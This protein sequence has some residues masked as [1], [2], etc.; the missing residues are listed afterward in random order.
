MVPGS[1]GRERAG[2]CRD[3]VGGAEKDL[4]STG[5]DEQLPPEDDREIC[6]GSARGRAG[7]VHRTVRRDDGRL[8]AHRRLQA[9]GG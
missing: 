7:D 6:Q 1:L 9:Q 8:G 4:Q 5:V 2:L 3:A